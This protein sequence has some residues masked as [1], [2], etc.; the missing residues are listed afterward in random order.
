MNSFRRKG[1]CGRI[2]LFGRNAAFSELA[3]YWYKNKLETLKSPRWR[4]SEAKLLKLADALEAGSNSVSL[5]SSSCLLDLGILSR[6][7]R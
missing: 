1:E 2:S 3:S 6:S 7:G 5:A 4:A